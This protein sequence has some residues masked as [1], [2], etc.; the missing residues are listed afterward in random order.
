MK[1][2]NYNIDENIE[3]FSVDHIKEGKEVRII[4]ISLCP[5]TSGYISLLVMATAMGEY[6][7]ET[8]PIAK[9]TAAKRWITVGRLMEIRANQHNTINERVKFSKIDHVLDMTEYH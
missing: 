2:W 8:L 3:I 7:R 9:G 1:R 6:P 4:W 5:P